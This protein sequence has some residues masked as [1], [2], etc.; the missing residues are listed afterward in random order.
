MH[1]RSIS[2][3]LLGAALMLF[4]AVGCSTPSGTGTQAADD[5]TDDP[6]YLSSA[7]VNRD[8][9][10]IICR[11]QRPT[12]SRLSEKICMTARQWYQMSQE[13][14]QVLDRAQRAPQAGVDE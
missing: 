8:P 5:A 14:K 10:R 3:N 6:E 2:L 7:D 9:D 1:L 12:G 13:S 4:I 11:R